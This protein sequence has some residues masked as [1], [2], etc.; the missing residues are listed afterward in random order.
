MLFSAPIIRAVADELRNRDFPLVVDP[1]SV[2]QSGSRLLQE[3]AVTALVE[4]ML[5]GLRPADPQPPRGGNA[6]RYE[7][8]Q[9]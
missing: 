2:S 5:P 6:H 1:V 8:Q 4:E 7:H 9:P 3:D